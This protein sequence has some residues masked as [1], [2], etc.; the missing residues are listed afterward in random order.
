MTGRI[1]IRVNS[2]VS[3][4]GGRGGGRGG[5]ANATRVRVGFSAGRMDIRGKF[6]LPGRGSVEFVRRCV[7]DMVVLSG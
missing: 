7:V 2:V 5:S 1:V 4:R 3:G 6:V